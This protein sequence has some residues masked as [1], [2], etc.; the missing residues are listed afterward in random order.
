MELKQRIMTALEREEP[1]AVPL[2]ELA[3][4]EPSIIGIARHFMDEKELPEPKLAMDMSDQERFKTLTALVT[5]IR[6]L[7]VEGVTAIGLIPRERLS[8]THMKDAMGVVHHLSQ[9]G[10]PM[11]IQGPI[12]D[13]S[14]L[15][16]FRIRKP[17][18]PDFV[19]LDVLRSMLPDRAVAFDMQAT[20]KLSWAL[21]GAME[22]L[23]VDYYINPGLV[24]DLARI[25]TDYCLEVVEKALDKGADF[26]VMDGDL[27]FNQGPI[28]SPAHYDE[29]IGPFHKQ[30]VDLVHERGQ[31]IIKHSDGNLKPLIPNL[32]QAGFDG[33]HPIQPQCMDIGEVKKEFGSR[34][35][36]MGNIDC[37]YLLVFKEPQDV[38]DA[39]K[40]TISKAAT[41]GG[42]I[43][44][45]SNSIHPGVKPE[46]YIAMVEAAR[47]FG[48]YTPQA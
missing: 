8:D 47:D 37:S 46:N 17:E 23:L 7:G 33:I 39:V 40:E 16:G 19:M 2:W 25:V 6:E 18:D 10:E 13:A 15:K 20:F 5:F 12:N 24:R 28:M 21:R 1:D 36:I 26:I 27:A 44:S 38:R 45:S 14:D 29:Y 3:F 48:G 4:N 9:V 30:I 22:K 43:L 11:P 34:L 31:K 42:Y 32:M 35:C 41:G